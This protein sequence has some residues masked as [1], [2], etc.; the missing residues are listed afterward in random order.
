MCVKDSFVYYQMSLNNAGFFPKIHSTNG[1][2][3]QS[4]PGCK[5]VFETLEMSH[6]GK[7]VII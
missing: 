3:I 7:H 1:R 4:F 6:K 5:A 2:K